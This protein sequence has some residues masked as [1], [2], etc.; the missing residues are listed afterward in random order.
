M[1]ARDGAVKLLC[2]EM[3]GGLGRWLRAAGHDA[4]SAGPGRPDAE[5]VE[6]A[7]RDA[8]LLLTCDRALARHRR[9]A[10]RVLTLPS[11]G[12]EA[13]VAALGARVAID[14]LHAPFT[15]C[16]VDNSPLRTAETLERA[17]VPAG[18]RS[19]GGPVNACP[20]CGRFYWPGSHLRRMRAR[21]ERWQARQMP[22][23]PENRVRP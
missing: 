23:F 4:A 13:T 18:A 15:R 1:T 7:L 12:I 3:L 19:L 9:A 11:A 17:R 14:W 16:L 5:L 2:D 21:L 6:Y 10:G 22:E 8:R 20:A